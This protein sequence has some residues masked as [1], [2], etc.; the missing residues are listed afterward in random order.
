MNCG[1]V[2]PAYLT[3]SSHCALLDPISLISSDKQANLDSC[4]MSLAW[5]DIRARG[6]ERRKIARSFSKTFSKR[7]QASDFH[8]FTEKYRRTPS[9]VT[10]T[11][12]ERMNKARERKMTQKFND[13]AK[14]LFTGVS[15][16]LAFSCGQQRCIRSGKNHRTRKVRLYR[17]KTAI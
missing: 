12:G 15:R 11:N 7:D 6:L 8:E 3:G 5:R 16:P 2:A 9:T 10:G 13:S 17:R 1:P 14:S 4:E